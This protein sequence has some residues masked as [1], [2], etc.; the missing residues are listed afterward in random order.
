MGNENVGI[1]MFIILDIVFI[2]GVISIIKEI[3]KK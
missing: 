1:T 3:T 2:I